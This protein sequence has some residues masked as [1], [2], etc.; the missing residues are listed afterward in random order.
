[1]IVGVPKEVKDHEFRV[2]LTP[3]GTQE[4]ASRGHR[5][6]VQKKAG[7]GSGI[8]D[9][10]YAKFG[11]TLVD[12]AED[13]YS[14]AELIIKVKE[15]V[16]SEYDLLQQ[17]QVLFT[18]LHLAA[19]PPLLE[20]LLKKN[21]TAI[22][23]ETIERN[24]SLPLLTPMSEIAGRMAVLV[25]AQY[26]Q[27]LFGGNGLLI[28]SVPGVPRVKIVILGGG[29]VGTN[30][31]KLAVGL[32]GDVVII[33]HSLPRLRQ[34]DDI[35]SSRVSTVYSNS[36]NIYN[37]IIQ[38]DLLIGAVLVA[39]DRAPCLVPKDFLKAMKKG[40]LIVDVAVDQGGC[41]ETTHA[42]THSNPVYKVDGIMHYGVA[43]MPGAVPRTS[44]LA[45]TNATLPYLLNMVDQGVKVSLDNDSGFMKG[46]NT[47]R[48]KVTHPV[49]AK[50]LGHPFTPPAE[51]Y[52]EAG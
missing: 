46:L 13:V 23:Y 38:A 16:E 25:G 50:S 48:G 10:F 31:A 45:L 21:I 15:P 26:M 1:M 51:C 19:V 36:L 9:N 49:V 4:L 2:A 17:N 42:T 33:D 44:T 14:N 43:N 30:A 29:T 6:L 12:T 24:G 37:E 47:Y 40:S 5:V 22:A 20:I 18:Y 11:A 7:E 35:F 39:G 34:L 3:A 8:S 32:G 27:K 41:V 28:S 52:R